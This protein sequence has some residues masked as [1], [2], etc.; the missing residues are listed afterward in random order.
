MEGKPLGPSTLDPS[1]V[2]STEDIMRFFELAAITAVAVFVLSVVGVA[3]GASVAA[4]VAAASL[5]VGV[6]VAAVGALIL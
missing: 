4:P 3:L 1:Y 5:G 6:A 2:L